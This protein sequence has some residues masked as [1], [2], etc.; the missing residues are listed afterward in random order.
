VPRQNGFSHPRRPSQEDVER[1]LAPEGGFE[2]TGELRNFGVT[3][4]KTTWEISI[5]ENAR[6][7]Y[8]IRRVII[9]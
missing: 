6:F 9:C 2:R 4:E 1:T 7:D 5:L 3:M 8:H